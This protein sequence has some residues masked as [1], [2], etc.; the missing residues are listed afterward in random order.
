MSRSPRPARPGRALGLGLVL[1]ALAT[2]TGSA[3]GAECSG[4]GRPVKLASVI[5]AA[6]G[7]LKAR[8]ERVVRTEAEWK[9][10]WGRLGLPL[11][12]AVAAPAIDFAKSMVLL[13]AAGEGRGIVEVEV[14]RVERRTGCLQV[15]VAERA[16][17]P[18]MSAAQFASFHPFHAVRVEAQPGPVVFRYTKRS[19]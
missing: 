6:I 18:N 13:V 2:T 10:L 12:P 9:A 16:V 4:P 1:L 8:E 14:T 11:R 17:P 3:P 19:R 5:R 7:D 15:T